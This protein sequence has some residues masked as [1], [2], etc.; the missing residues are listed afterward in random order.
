M[1]APTLRRLALAAAWLPFAAQALCTSDG[2]T[3]PTA[4]LER[5]IAADCATCW[6]EP[7]TP[8]PA[9]DALALDW[10]LPGRKGDDAP[11]SAAALDEA[12]QRMVFLRRPQPRRRDAVDSA[13]EGPAMQL[14]L[15]QGAAFNDYLAA[16]IALQRPGREPWHAWLLLIESVPAG[17]EGS[18]V[19][20]NL[21]RNVFTPDSWLRPVGRPPRLTELRSMQ[22]RAGAQPDRLRLVALLHDGKGR[23]R[24]ISQT[25]CRE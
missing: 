21:V 25:E 4:V 16:S 20:R 9:P 1:A 3:R 12:R 13:R 14:R 5:F 24:A 19:A 22:I 17:T 7:G 10:V 11:L 23:L 15:A 2:A 8:R 18:P 6:A